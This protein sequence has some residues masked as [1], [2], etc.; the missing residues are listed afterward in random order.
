MK[1]EQFWGW[2]H[3]LFSK[4]YFILKKKT[5]EISRTC[6]KKERVSNGSKSWMGARRTQ[7]TWS[8][9]TNMAEGGAQEVENNRNKELE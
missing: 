9:E 4:L 2:V 8:S 5:M 7:K 3:Q 1:S 6:I